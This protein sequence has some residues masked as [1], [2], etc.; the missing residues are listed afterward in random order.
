VTGGWRY[1]H[2]EQQDRAGHVARMGEKRKFGGRRL[3]GKP[4]RRWEDN[5]K[6]DLRETV[7]YEEHSSGGRQGPIEGSC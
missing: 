3:L 2:N 5:T 4:R 7:W 1:L 6:T